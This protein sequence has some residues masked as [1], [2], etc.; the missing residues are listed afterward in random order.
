MR[1]AVHDLSYNLTR[2]IDLL[3]ADGLKAEMPPHGRAWTEVIMFGF[4]VGFNL[5]EF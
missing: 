3:Y 1:Y 5:K 2:G 4:S